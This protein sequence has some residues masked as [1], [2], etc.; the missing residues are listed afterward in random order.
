MSNTASFTAEPGKRI[1]AG[2]FDFLAILSLYLIVGATAEGIGLDPAHWYIFALV[3]LTY[4]F[5]CLAFRQGRTLGKT[6][7]DICVVSATGQSLSLLQ[8]FLRAGLRS[9]PLLLLS[10][11][12]WEVIGSLLFLILAITEFNLLERPPLRQT[13]ADI[14]AGSI[15]MKLP[16]L[17]PHRAPAGPMYSAS[18]A[19]FGYPPQRPPKGCDAPR[20]DFTQI[21]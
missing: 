13:L 12:N 7:V 5:T 2:G 3:M 10:F 1:W 18:D 16:P 21:R 14:L 20:D 19:E 4:H 11:R 17:Q 8:S 6:A 15:V 9:F